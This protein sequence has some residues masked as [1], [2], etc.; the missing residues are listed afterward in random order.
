[1]KLLIALALVAL[2]AAQTYGG[3]ADSGPAYPS[4]PAA[5]PSYGQP[6]YW[7]QGHYGHH[8]HH[9]RS[10][11]SSSES[12]S[13]SRSRSK[14]ESKEHKSSISRSSIVYSVLECHCKDPKK[15]T[16][17]GFKKISISYLK[18]KDGC[19]RAV[20]TC[21]FDN[22]VYNLYGINDKNDNQVLSWGQNVQRVIKCN[23]KGK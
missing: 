9:R 10:S 17:N 21:P 16:D 7:P 13:R 1:M 15:Y 18:D 5:N 14:S 8:G 19:K 6:S 22:D 23:K 11:S 4:Q 3:A 2:T 20:L 12:R